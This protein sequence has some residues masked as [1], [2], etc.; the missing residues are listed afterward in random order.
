MIKISLTIF[1]LLLTFPITAQQSFTLYGDNEKDN[2][3]TAVEFQHDYLYKIYYQKVG[4]TDKLINGKEYV[5]YYNRSKLKPLLFKD[6]KHTASISLNERKYSDVS[7]EYDT[8]LDEVICFDKSRVINNRFYQIALNK[9]PIVGFGLYTEQ[10]S[11]IFRHFKSGKEINFNLEDGFYEVVYE[12][13]SKYIIKH[14]STVFEKEGIDEYYY[15]PVN[16]V[17]VG[18]AFH[19]IITSGGFIKLFGEKSDEIRKFMRTYKV[20]IRKTDKK[21]IAKILKFYDKL[22][23]A[24]S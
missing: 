4:S 9:D 2:Y 20:N 17:K 13:G 10:D 5:P 24:E 8:Y 6:K 22:I 21:Q 1:I 14:K 15:T 7:L 12:G 18:N 23:K 11:L 19:R 3:K 16:Y